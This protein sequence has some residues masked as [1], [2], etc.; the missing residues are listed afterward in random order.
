[1]IL[2]F[3]CTWPNLSGSHDL[4]LIH[5]F[6]INNKDFN[7]VLTSHL[8]LDCIINNTSDISSQKWHKYLALM[9]CF[10]HGKNCNGIT[11]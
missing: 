7:S 5:I 2:T 3:S 11:T 10:H 4:L 8:L 1:M 9:F 6:S